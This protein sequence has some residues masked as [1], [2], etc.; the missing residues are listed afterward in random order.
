[1]RDRLTR[2]DIEKMKKELDY[3]KLEVRPKAIDDVKE[4]RA[5]GDLSENFEYKAAKQF[6]NRNESRIRY[7]ENMIK[8]AVIIEDESNDFEIGLNDSVRVFMGNTGKEVTIKIVT[9]IRANALKNYI[10]IESPVGKALLGHVKGDEVNVKV[11]ESVSF[12]VR[13]LE[14]IKS[15][16]ENEEISTY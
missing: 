13:V 9:T 16:E 6:K 2:G 10:S 14:I 4:A 1:M 12:T 15:D 3:R 5:L 7:L 8:T 11:S